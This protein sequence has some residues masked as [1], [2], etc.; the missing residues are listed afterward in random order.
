MR[1][2]LPL[3]EDVARRLPDRRLMFLNYG[4]ADG[5]FAWLRPSDGE[6]KY[7]LALVRRVLAG[8]E[9]AGRDVLEAGCGRGGNL[10]YLAHYTAA[11]RLVGLDASEGNLA[12]CRRVHGGGRA[13]F[14]R[15]DAQ[16]L[17]FAPASFDL[18]LNLESSHCYPRLGDFLAEAYRVLRPGGCLAY[19]DF[20][21]VQAFR[22][23]WAER[24]DDLRRSPF[25]AA[26]AEDIGDAVREALK[27]SDGLSHLL[28]AME[29]QANRD[30]VQFLVRTNEAMRVTLAAR[31]GRY[32]VW[33]L[34]K[35]QR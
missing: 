15:G 7:H 8:V 3:Y 32:L 28:L 14:L 12:F 10:Y 35:P 6:W 22:Q 13:A 2:A 26:V 24:E 9:V 33:R 19:A 31:Q 17:P 16:Q 21:H 25:C 23:D 29:N 20:W 18:L 34:V 27:R 4:Y 5:D 11:A 1:N 30:L